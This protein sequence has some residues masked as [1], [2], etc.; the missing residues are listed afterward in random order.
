MDSLVNEQ[1]FALLRGDRVSF[2]VLDRICGG[3]APSC[4][5]ITGG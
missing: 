1:D 2:S 3:P 5:A 4:G